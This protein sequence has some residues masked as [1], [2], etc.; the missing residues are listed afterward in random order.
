MPF[1]PFTMEEMMSEWENVVDYNLSE[2]GVRPMTI[3]E[4]VDDP[5]LR[6]RLLYVGLDYSQSN[7]TPE[8]RELIC[9]LYPG[10]TQHNVLVTTGAAE[11][12]RPAVSF[13]GRAWLGA[14]PGR[15]G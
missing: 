12:N 5:T 7:G 9:A 1:Y 11:A 4:L 2:S 10:A 6:D 14:R 3:H 8:L 13:E 15:A